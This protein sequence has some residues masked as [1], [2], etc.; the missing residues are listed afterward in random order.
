[1][2][3]EVIVAPDVVATVITHLNS[4]L[5]PPVSNQVPNPREFEFVVVV[6]TGGVM[7]GLVVDQAQLTFDAWGD[8]E[9]TAHDLAQLARAHV[10]AMRGETIDG[11]TVYRINE[12]AGPAALPDDES[13]Q[14]RF[15]WTMQV[16]V[17]A[18]A[19]IS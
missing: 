16:N 19:L 18:T 8:T 4:V 2:T 1:M 17:R 14:A 9:E 6:R 5:T 11:V 10:H 12:F 15:R 7:Q 3:N 13:G